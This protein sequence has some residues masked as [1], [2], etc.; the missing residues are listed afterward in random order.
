MRL[1]AWC[2]TKLEVLPG[3]VA[4]SRQYNISLRNRQTTR[5]V[6]GCRIGEMRSATTPKWSLAKYHLAWLANVEPGE[7]GFAKSAA[8]GFGALKLPSKVFSSGFGCNAAKTRRKRGSGRA[9]RRQR[10]AAIGFSLCVVGASRRQ[11]AG[12]RTGRS[13]CRAA[14]Q[15]AFLRTG[16]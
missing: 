12:F 4:I 16:C 13:A 6:V 8:V 2:Q 11:P 9:R 10:I 5:P 1:H 14:H 7:P 3:N 15:P